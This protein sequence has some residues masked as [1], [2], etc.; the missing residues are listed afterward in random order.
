[1]IKCSFTSRSLFLAM[2][3]KKVF[4]EKKIFD[5]RVLSPPDGNWRCG[6]AVERPND[7]RR[8]RKGWPRRERESRAGSSQTRWSRKEK[9][10]TWVCVCVCVE[11]RV[12]DREREREASQD[13][14]LSPL[15]CVCV[16]V[17]VCVCILSAG[18]SLWK[19]KEEE[20]TWE[21]DLAHAFLS[22]AICGVKSASETNADFA[23]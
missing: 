16:C 22:T 12:S 8:K 19:K 10:N 9:E 6:E 5:V 13:I 3:W 14:S 17:C 2:G 1:M 11:V 20:E 18:Q 21:R 23:V 7:R 15:T 4:V